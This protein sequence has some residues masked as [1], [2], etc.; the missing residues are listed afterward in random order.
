MATMA[1]PDSDNA[2]SYGSAPLSFRAPMSNCAKSIIDRKLRKFASETSFATETASEC[3]LERE[4]PGRTRVFT[5]RTVPRRLLANRGRN[6]SDGSGGSEAT[7][8]S[9]SATPRRAL[10]RPKSQ[11]E[12]HTSCTSATIHSLESATAAIPCDE[13]RASHVYMIDDDSVHEFEDDDVPHMFEPAH[14]TLI[15]NGENSS[16]Q[17]MTS[18][19]MDEF[20]ATTACT[21]RSSGDE[22]SANGS[23]DIINRVYIRK[24]DPRQR[25]MTRRTSHTLLFV[26]EQRR[27]SNVS[28][29]SV[30]S[31][32]CPV[33]GEDV[34]LAPL[35]PPRFS[36]NL[37]PASS[38][39]KSVQTGAPAIGFRP[40]RTFERRASQPTLQLELQAKIETEPPETN[41]KSKMLCKRVSWLSM[42]SLQEGVKIG[43]QPGS[44]SKAC[45]SGGGGG[46]DSRSASQHGSQTQLFGEHDFDSDTP[47]L[48]TL[49]W[50]N[51]GNEYDNVTLM[52]AKHEK[53]PMKDFGS[54]IRATMDID[55]LL[56]KAVLLLDLQET[57]LEEIFAK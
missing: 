55:H 29:G 33:E 19:C 10:R 22:A 1:T 14:V 37:S 45:G 34:N 52:Y 12:L 31:C 15:V 28:G 20:A 5:V 40:L 13:R 53:I 39:R 56:N 43:R 23:G 30:A 46:N 57:S 4:V 17:V 6:D 54:E 7:V 51:A 27:I 9:G 38:R 42:K 16:A 2:E 24:T 8:A 47:P 25:T 32:P 11:G 21:S 36:L 49:S 3:S 26:P 18:T 44:P 48:D 41:D 50:S 35:P